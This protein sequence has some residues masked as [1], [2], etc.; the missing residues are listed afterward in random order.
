RHAVAAGRVGEAPVAREVAGAVV[1]DVGGRCGNQLAVAPGGEMAGPPAASRRHARARLQRLEERPA[2]ER[3]VVGLE[4]AV[5]G[6]ARNLGEI[7][8]DLELDP[9]FGH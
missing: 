6:F 7:A 2:H 1:L 3:V 5:P 4:Y 9:A 8:I